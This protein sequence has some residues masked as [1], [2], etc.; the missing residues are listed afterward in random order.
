[1]CIK[2]SITPYAPQNWNS[3]PSHS[4][5]KKTTLLVVFFL[6][7]GGF[8][9]LNATRMSVAGEGMTEPLKYFRIAI[10]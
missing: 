10:M 2:V 8:E 4:A 1:M 5:K 6:V 3:N 9:R 7:I